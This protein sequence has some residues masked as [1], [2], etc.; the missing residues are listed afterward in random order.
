MTFHN[1]YPS[2]L[3]MESICITKS[4]FSR[5]EDSLDGLRLGIRVGRDIKPLSE[6]RYRVELT[7]EVSDDDR[8]LVAEATSV[9]VFQLLSG[10]QGL[11]ERNAIAIM[12][13]YLRSYISTLTTQPGMAPVV[14]PPINILS[15]LES[16]N[17]A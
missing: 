5:V 17:D 2:P 13:P 9:G 11:I 15:L 3:V 12:F 7:I 16:G 14:L 10:H 1:D 4:S 8:K 6:N